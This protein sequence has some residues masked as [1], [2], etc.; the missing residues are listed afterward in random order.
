M[1]KHLTTK[2]VAEL[3]GQGC[4]HINLRGHEAAVL[5]A[6]AALNEIAESAAGDQCGTCRRACRGGATR[7]DC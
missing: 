3:G 7:L 4:G 1:A 5:C 6:I 2:T